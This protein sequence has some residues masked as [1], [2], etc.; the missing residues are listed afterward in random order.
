MMNLRTEYYTPQE[1]QQISTKCRGYNDKNNWGILKNDSTFTKDQ[2][3]IL[4]PDCM[5]YPERPNGSEWGTCD[6]DCGIV[7]PPEENKTVL[8]STK[9]ES[10]DEDRF[11]CYKMQYTYAE[12]IDSNL[13]P[14]CSPKSGLCPNEKE[15]PIYSIDKNNVDK[16]GCYITSVKCV[17][18]EDLNNETN[19]NSSGCFW[20]PYTDDYGSEEIKHKCSSLPTKDSKQNCNDSVAIDND[21]NKKT[22]QDIGKIA[23]SLGMDEKCTTSAKY[24]N[25]LLKSNSSSKSLFGKRKTSS[26]EK[27]TNSASFTTE[28]CDSSLAEINTYESNRVNQQCNLMK[29]TNTSAIGVNN[30]QTITIKAVSDPTLKPLLAN[31]W[32][33]IEAQKADLAKNADRLGYD[34]PQ[35]KFLQRA[36]E[37]DQDFFSKLSATSGSIIIDDSSITNK[38]GTN[39]ASE[40]QIETSV[41]SSLATD[42]IDQVKK[43]AEQTI[44]QHTGDAS[45]P[46]NTKQLIDEEVNNNLTTINKSINEIIAKSNITVENN[47]N[48]TLSAYSVKITNSN[49]ENNINVEIAVKDVIKAASTLGTIIGKNIISGASTYIAN[50]DSDISANELAK[51]LVDTEVQKT[52]FCSEDNRCKRVTN[53]NSVPQ[54]AKTYEDPNLCVKDKCIRYSNINSKCQEDVDGKYTTKEECENPPVVIPD[55]IPDDIP[56]VIPP[57]PP[58]PSSSSNQRKNIIMIVAGIIL[59]LFF[60]GIIYYFTKKNTINKNE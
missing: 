25:E 55:F 28:G 6:I 34:S 17:K 49:L 8:S 37:E 15:T 19:C 2:V 7:F 16:N 27:S 42:Y 53:P 48:I 1:E 32:K 31:L 14:D 21:K 24:Q 50:S 54:G 41:S 10:R 36:V 9:S 18:C 45:L 12:N 43:T 30:N 35:V 58:P 52:Y 5:Y 29:A 59:V 38:S 57:P 26:S 13:N 40:L 3:C 11:G 39:I 46:N 60:G 47:Q 44:Q 4:D 22:A 51:S 20:L 56:D 33:S 23:E